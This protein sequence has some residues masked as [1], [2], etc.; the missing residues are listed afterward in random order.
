VV[1]V[2]AKPSRQGHSVI[3]LSRSIVSPREADA[4]RRV[5][6][7]DGYLGMGTEVQRFEA[8]LAAFFG[9]G[10][11]CVATCNSGT[12]A[13]HLAVAATLNPG[14]EILVQSLTF[15]ATFQGIAAADVVPVGCEILPDTITIDLDDARR[16]ITP[17]TRAIM[18]VHYAS[19]PAGLDAIYAFAAEHDLRVIE[20]AAHAFGCTVNGAMV[21]SKSDVACFSFD[22]IKNITSAEGGL[23]VSADQKVMQRVRDAR[24]LGVE[25]DTERRFA[26]ERSW[27]FDVSRQGYRYHMSNVLAAIGRVQLQR[28]QEEFADARV[29]LSR[30]YLERL[31]GVKGIRLLETNLGPVVPHLMAIRVLDGRRNAV[32]AAL[33]GAGIETGTHYKPNHLLTYFRQ[34]GSPLPVT[35]EVA[36]QLLSLP[37]HPGLDLAA[38]ETVCDALIAA[39]EDAR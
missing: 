31:A 18:P 24:L 12:A 26:G 9:V 16:R 27:E 37:L 33:A 4:V 13:V 11:E 30:R 17:R 15:V 29:R 3:R 22:G 38:V 2:K 8:E 21:G 1:A 32:R 35:E 23:V 39:L 7:E 28:F 19:N 5:L 6:L 36:G 25:R 34:S 14:D 10:P 20:D